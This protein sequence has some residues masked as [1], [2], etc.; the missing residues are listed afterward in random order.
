[1]QILSAKPI[2][3]SIR[4]QIKDRVQSFKKNFHR[5]P[6][7]SVI[8]VGDHPASLIY[9][10]KKGA[11]A[12]AAGMEHETIHFPEA[13]PPSEVQKKIKELN[14][15]DT[16]DGI[17][18]QRPLPDSFS[19][20]EL[21]SWISAE[22]DVD[23]L[24]PANLGKL[25]LGLPCLAPC[26]PLGIIQLL[27]YYKIPLSG[28]TACVIG[29]SPIVGKPMAM[30]LLQENATVIQCHSKTAD[31]RQFTRK[32][33]L[34]IVAAGKPGLIDQT[35]IQKGATVIDVGVHRNSENKLTGDV[36]FD[37]AAQIAGAIT[38]VPGGVGPMTISML[39]SNT[40]TAAEK[41]SSHA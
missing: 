32:A 36:V 41:R 23:G 2:S 17:L 34:L 7:L 1:M 6:K 15:D 22:K 19:E 26:T 38:P 39:L 37:S 40:I 3:E 13:A 11:A 4:S 29:R 14:Q 18:I 28:Q 31:L 12:T 24:H 33:D 21:F 25:A 8:L 30:L 10:Q 5:A 20:S 27:K 9:V 16:V 35:H